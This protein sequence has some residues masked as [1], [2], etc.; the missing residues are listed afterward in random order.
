MCTL[1]RVVCFTV[2]VLES[3]GGLFGL[4]HGGLVKDP[5]PELLTNEDQRLAQFAQFAHHTKGF[6]P[7]HAWL[8]VWHLP[9]PCKPGNPG[10]TLSNR[11]N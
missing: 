5:V 9:P 11:A 8:A 3:G 6:G 1:N 10:S 7:A 2:T 4:A